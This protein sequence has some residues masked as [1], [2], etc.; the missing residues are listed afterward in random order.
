[1]GTRDLASDA[2]EMEKDRSR[3]AAYV[4]GALPGAIAGAVAGLYGADALN[5]YVDVLREGPM[6]V[7]GLVDIVGMAVGGLVGD[8]AGGFSAVKISA[9][10]N[11]LNLHNNDGNY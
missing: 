3:L 8:C 9:L 11:S 6:I 7:R 10:R 4:A 5:D 1:M 2:R